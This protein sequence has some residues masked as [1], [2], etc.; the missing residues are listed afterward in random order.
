MSA[1]C[2]EGCVDATRRTNG[3]WEYQVPLRVYPVRARVNEQY[4][5]TAGVGGC[6]D[7]ACVVIRGGRG[8]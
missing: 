1:V 4:M 5:S 2:S 7:Y 3:V 8:E 6:A